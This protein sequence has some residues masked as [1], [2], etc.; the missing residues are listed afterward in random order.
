MSACW[1]ELKIPPPIVGMLVAIAMWAVA[2]IGPQFSLELQVRYTLVCILIVVGVAFDLLG[3]AA[4]RA[5]R[6]TIN[7]LKPNHASALVTG[8]V[9][10][11]TRNP[12]YVGMCCFCLLGESTSHRC[13]PSLVYRSL[14]CTSHVFR[15]SQRN[16]P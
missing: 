6:T 3:L 15:F 10:R 13:Y 5:S 11:V 1:L 12:M 7:P 8:G 4:F 9:Y 16:A 2:K 14:S